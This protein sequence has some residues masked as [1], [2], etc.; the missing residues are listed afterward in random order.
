M[1]SKYTSRFVY[2]NTTF[3]STVHVWTVYSL[4]RTVELHPDVTYKLVLLNKIPIL[5]NGTFHCA[6]HPWIFV[7]YVLF[8]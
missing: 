6:A 4:I 7:P 8:N 2:K 5:L 1:V 3:V